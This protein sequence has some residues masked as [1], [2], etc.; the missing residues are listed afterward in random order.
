[1]P[2]YRL[3]E[4]RRFH[5]LQKSSLLLH[6]A[7][8][9]EILPA[10]GATSRYT[11]GKPSGRDVWLLLISYQHTVHTSG[12]TTSMRSG[13][14]TS[15]AVVVGDSAWGAGCRCGSRASSPGSERRG[16]RGTGREG[17]AGRHLA[18]RGREGREGAS[19]NAVVVCDGAP[20]V[21][22][23]VRDAAA[24]HAVVV[25]VVGCRAAAAVAVVVV[26]AGY[27][28]AIGGDVVVGDCLLAIAVCGGGDGVVGACWWRCTCKRG[29]KTKFGSNS[30][31]HCATV[32]TGA[33]S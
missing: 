27:A 18:W 24:G 19:R 23:V 31:S 10:L 12:Y 8:I 28:G 22:V 2:L 15:R 29:N 30:E 4:S 11:V 26:V 32:F 6:C 20:R 17:R 5:S 33:P 16:G 25:V 9:L 21:H 7:N 3:V 14:S 13:G 1:M